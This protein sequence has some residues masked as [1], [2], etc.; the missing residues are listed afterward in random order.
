[1]SVTYGRTVATDAFPPEAVPGPTTTRSKKACHYRLRPRAGSPAMA[2]G[3]VLA[4]WSCPADLQHV[5]DRA[6]TPR[7]RLQRHPLAGQPT[8]EGFR[9]V[10]TEDFWYLAHF[11]HQF[12]NSFYVGPVGDVPDV[13]DRLAGQLHDRTDAIRNGWM[14]SNAALM[15]YVIPASFLAIPMYRIMSI[16][17][18][19]EQPVVGHP[20]ADDVRH[21]LC[22][23]HLLAIR[24]VDPDGT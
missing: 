15:T 13:A 12:G 22:D 3:V 19:T 17:G 7:R 10:V 4:V 2:F 18:L 14:L 11:W 6:S 20:G 16:Y 9:V 1:M 8:L 21:A 5:D 24:Q 23:L